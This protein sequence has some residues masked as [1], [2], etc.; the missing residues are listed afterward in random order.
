METVAVHQSSSLSRFAAYQAGVR[1]GSGFEES[2]GSGIAPLARTELPRLAG[3]RRLD[4]S[5]FLMNL[6]QTMRENDRDRG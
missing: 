1:S 6:Q 2:G 3:Q 4:R 5:T